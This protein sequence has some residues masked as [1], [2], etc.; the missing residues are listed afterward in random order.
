MD[1]DRAGKQ[2]QSITGLIGI[3]GGLAAA[4]AAF[5][6]QVR[7]AVEVFTSLSFGWLIAISALLLVVGI[8]LFISGRGRASRLIDPDALRLNSQ[9]PEHLIGR[10]EDIR[11]LHEKCGVRAVVFLVGE[12]GSGKSALA[13]AGLV[14]TATK[15]GRLIPVYLDMANLDWQAGPL[16]SLADQFWRVL[17]ADERKSLEIEKPPAGQKLTRSMATCYS[18]L[19]KKPLVILDQIDDYQL[20]HRERFVPP[21]S[22]SWLAVD[23]LVSQNEFWAALASLVREQQIHLLVVTRSDNADGLE[24]LRL[25]ASPLMQRLDPLPTGFALK[26]VDQLTER[27]QG[28]PAVIEAPERGWDRLRIRLAD[29]LERGG[30]V[31]PQQLKLALLGLARLKALSIP[32]YERVGGIEG[33]EARYIEDAL[34]RAASRAGVPMASVRSAVMRLVERDGSRRTAPVSAEQLAA[35]IGGLHP[36]KL[37]TAFEALDEAEI[38]RRRDA[39]GAIA[40]QLDHD[41]LARGLIRVERNADRWKGMLVRRAREFEDASGS[42]RARWRA[43]LNLRE[44][45]GL[46]FARLGGKFRYGTERRFAFICT[47]PYAAIATVIAVTVVTAQIAVDLVKAQNVLTFVTP[48]RSANLYEYAGLSMIAEMGDVGRAWYANELLSSAQYERAVVEKSEP[49]VRALVGLDEGRAVKLLEWFIAP[50]QEN[51]AASELAAMALIEQLPPAAQRLAEQPRASN[52]METAAGN[53]SVA[54][55]SAAPDTGKLIADL[56][57]LRGK[58]GVA[59]ESARFRIV[60][61]I[62]WARHQMTAEQKAEV[63]RAVGEELDFS[64]PIPQAIGPLADLYAAIAARLPVSDRIEAVESLIQ[65]VRKYRGS[66]PI[67]QALE[68][69]LETLARTLPADVGERLAKQVLLELK[70]VRGD[71]NAVLPLAFALAATAPASS[72]QLQEAAAI[73]RGEL[74]ANHGTGS[75]FVWLVEAHATL[76]LGRPEGVQERGE[77]FRATMAELAAAVSQTGVEHPPSVSEAFEPCWANTCFAMFASAVLDMASTQP[78]EA[79]AALVTELLKVPV[80][81][82]LRMTD[83]LLARLRSEPG[84]ETLGL[85]DGGLWAFVAWAE[86]RGLDP[87]SPLDVDRLFAALPQ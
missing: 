15:D 65:L 59:A 3:V 68:V 11:I 26:V 39:D 38:L 61:S 23:D 76:T 71:P 28:T 8:V 31:L 51:G 17:T 18:K 82:R 44:Q 81:S 52:V 45:L 37:T 49:I 20:R 62:A 12:S 16:A 22:R 86:Q 64:V 85:P 25:D 43:M 14:P 54:A 21:D 27:P 80:S 77:I 42:W 87:S 60:D 35:A 63:L 10:G 79:R 33:L 48:Y 83:A 2:L 32:R 56:Q 47:L 1:I 53:G 40:W 73:I 19:G 46:V 74:D 4:V 66:G 24:S 78:L 13:Q 84:A 7:E 5:N 6:K 72:A 57:A 36:A 29:D 9:K 34:S 50:A 58:I 70:A 30:A 75:T 67:L 55:P 41:Y 69:P